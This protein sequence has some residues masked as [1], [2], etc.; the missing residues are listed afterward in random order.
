MF[1]LSLY[2]QPKIFAD[3]LKTIIGE[4]EGSLTYLDYQTN[5]PFTMPANLI[6][7]Q[8]KNENKL[9]LKNI[10]PNEPKA[11]NKSKI[12][13]SKDG[14]LLN[15]N[16]VVSREKSENGHLQIQTEHEGKDDN[17]K[18]LIRYTYTIGTNVFTIRKEV[19]F[20]KNNDWIKRSEFSHT[21]KK[22]S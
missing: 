3:D 8:G 22:D 10:Y 21:R 9:V 11:N 13:I 18:A 20:N 1:S 2:S 12:K 14:S 6:I 16:K 15:K 4:W 5:E 19:Q 17:K 7:E